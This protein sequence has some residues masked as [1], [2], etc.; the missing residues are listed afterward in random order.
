MAS[1]TS[2]AQID[3]NIWDDP[4]FID[5]PSDSH[6]LLFISLFTNRHKNCT[7][8][9]E[10]HK[11]TICAGFS[12]ELVDEALAIFAE[13][14]RI[15]YE[16][17]YI[18]IAN[19]M[20][21]THYNTPEVRTYAI[22]HINS[23]PSSIKERHG[24]II[25]VILDRAGQGGGQ[26]PAQGGGQGRGQGGNMKY[27]I[28]NNNTPISPL[29]ENPD[30]KAVNDE[31]AR[32]RKEAVDIKLICNL[33]NEQIVKLCEKYG[34][35][36]VKVMLDIYYNWKMSTQK[37]RNDYLTMIRTGSWVE[38]E[39]NKRMAAGPPPATPRA[40]RPEGWDT[41]TTEQKREYNLRGAK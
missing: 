18:I 16:E 17:G 9:Y 21:R 12:P 20:K 19:W 37:K 5:L 39:A 13:S 33:T 7:G 4:W 31:I 3:P 41:W 35:E 38:D 34:I 15:Y 24:D 40:D 27:E 8:I 28:G 2:F 32:L 6:R 29:S 36:K 22:N 14:G 26:D 11:R 23:L 30:I 1:K 10:I 25:D